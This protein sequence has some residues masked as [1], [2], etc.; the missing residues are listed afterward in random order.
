MHA[1]HSPCS[2]GTAAQVVDVRRQQPCGAWFPHGLLVKLQAQLR[3]SPG[4]QDLAEQLE[5]ALQAH[6]S[7]AVEQSRILEQR[8]GVAH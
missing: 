4:L 2:A 6:C 1:G 5:A 7:S 3:A 8:M